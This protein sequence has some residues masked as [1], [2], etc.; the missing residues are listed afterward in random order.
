MEIGAI[1]RVLLTIGFLAVLL[2][3]WGCR[4]DDH[5]AGSES[6]AADLWFRYHF[7]G[8]RAIAQDSQ[9]TQLKQVA[10]FE[11]TEALVRHMLDRLARSPGVLAGNALTAEQVEEGASILR[12]MFD[13]LLVYESF[14]E[15]RGP[16][17]HPTEWL[18]G[19]ALPAE[20]GTAW[21]AALKRLR[22]TWELG[23]LEQELGGTA[24]ESGVIRR[25]SS[26]EV[27]RWAGLD[28]WLFVGIGDETSRLFDGALAALRDKRPPVAPQPDEWLT[29]EADLSR[30]A[31]PLGLPTKTSWP[32]TTLTMTGRDENLRTT[33]RFVFPEPVTGSLEA[34]RVPTNIACEPLVSFTA[35]RGVTPL[36]SQWDVLKSLAVE[37]VPNELY[38]WAQEH[39]AFTTFGA[40]PA[41]DAT[42][43]IQRIA[44]RAPRLLG[45]KWQQQGLAQ[46]EWDAANPQAIWKGLLMVTPHLRPARDAGTNFIVGG[47]FPQLRT[48]RPPPAELL[49]QFIQRPDVVYYD[50]EITQARVGQWRHL[51]QLFSVIVGQPQLSTNMAGLNWLLLMEREPLLGNTITEI[52][53]LSPKEWLLVRRSHIGFNGLELVALIRWIESRDFP[54]LSLRLPESETTKSRH[55]AVSPSP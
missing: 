9:G 30:L 37:P 10:G 6:S 24:A 26:P 22:E 46:I 16:A 18:L 42:N 13:D 28:G 51:S 53:T 35:M 12:P 27:V 1:M 54:R 44:E 33:M 2:A 31:R 3:L 34:W 20:R 36:L 29:T 39:T 38:F 48:S 5:A 23:E 55:R 47:L 17:T 52:T 8:A 4:P 32:R 25:A 14:L 15:V 49:A 7:L 21:N 43:Q 41:P 45:E 40:F 19:I 50:W 11:Q